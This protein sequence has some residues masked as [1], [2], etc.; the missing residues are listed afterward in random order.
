MLPPLPRHSDWRPCLALPSSRISLPRHSSRVGLRIV[1]F[2]ACSA[3]T[4]VTACTL[5]L[6]PY[7]VTSFT[8]RLQPFRYLH[9]CS[10]CF[11]LEHFAGWAFHP[12]DKRRL[13]TAHT[14]CG[15]SPI[16]RQ[17]LKPNHSCRSRQHWFNGRN[18]S[19]AVARPSYSRMRLPPAKGDPFVL[20]VVPRN[21]LT[22][23]TKCAGQMCKYSS[24]F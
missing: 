12:L 3:F 23:L 11:R 4:R 19:G 15:R 18:L 6:S 2:E 10:G 16:L 13:C 22:D 14:G 24:G 21:L 9:S 5:A 17:R 7:I 20:S 1:L 8:Q